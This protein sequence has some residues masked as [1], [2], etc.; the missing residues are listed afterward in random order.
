MIVPAM[1]RP[2]SFLLYSESSPARFGR[3]QQD[4]QEHGDRRKIDR[5]ASSERDRISVQLAVAIRAVRQMEA[6]ARPLN[7]RHHCQAHQAGSHKARKRSDRHR[8][9]D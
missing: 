8:S 6:L 5:Q 2:M 3:Q 4:N 7:Q 1:N 9:P